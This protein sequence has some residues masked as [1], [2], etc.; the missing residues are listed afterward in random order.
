MTLSVS[1]EQIA[2]PDTAFQ[3]P[4]LPV[5]NENFRRKSHDYDRS[6]IKKIDHYPS[7]P[8]DDD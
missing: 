1:K 4:F 2:H 3:R 8:M 5:T 6:A 7:S